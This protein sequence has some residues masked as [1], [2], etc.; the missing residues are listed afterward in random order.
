[1]WISYAEHKDKQ[2][3]HL[4]SASPAIKLIIIIINYLK[5]KPFH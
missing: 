5:L 3:T 4:N 2:E 1:M